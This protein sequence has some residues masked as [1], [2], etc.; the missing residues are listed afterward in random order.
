M[1]IASGKMI[2]VFGGDGSGVGGRVGGRVSMSISDGETWPDTGSA[3]VPGDVLLGVRPGRPRI[4]GFGAG[5][6]GIEPNTSVGRGGLTD[7]L[8]E[9]DTADPGP[10]PSA[11]N[12]W[13]VIGKGDVWRCWKTGKG[14]SVRTGSRFGEGD[15]GRSCVDDEAMAGDGEDDDDDDVV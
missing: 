11:E 1:I 14:T 9:T 15:V 10:G 7:C 5:G 13:V 6:S 3:G 2:L 4:P 8:G 12:E